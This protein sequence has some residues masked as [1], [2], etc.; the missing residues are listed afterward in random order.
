[1][2]PRPDDHADHAAGHGAFYFYATGLDW[3]TSIKITSNCCTDG[4][5]NAFG[6]G[7]FGI[8]RYNPTLS[9]PVLFKAGAS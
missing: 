8:A 1:L 6:I 3:V 9:A 7:E 4:N 2:E 5:E